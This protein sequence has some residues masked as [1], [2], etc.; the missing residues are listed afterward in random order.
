LL[1]LKKDTSVVP[2]LQNMLN[3]HPQPL[4]RIHALW[5]LEGLG[6]LTPA[7]ARTA[8][9]DQDPV[10][11]VQAIR[12][13]ESLLKAGDTSFV[14]DIKSTLADPH[15]QVKLQSVLTAKLHKF[16]DWKEIATQHLIT[17]GTPGLKDI[18]AALLT[19]GPTVSQSFSPA[20]R[21]QLERGL[22]IY[23]EVCFA[24]H[25][26]DGK[27]T[28]IPGSNGQTLAPPL[29]GSKTVRQGDALLR[30]LLNGLEG[31]I[32]GKT[33]ESQMIPQNTNSDEW[34]AD[35]SSYIRNAFGNSAPLVDSKQVKALRKEIGTRTTPWTIEEL[36]A[37]SPQPLPN[38]KSWKLGS[39]HNAEKLH[40]ALDGNSATRWD[41]K[42]EQAPDMWIEIGLPA[43]TKVNGMELH[44]AASPNDGPQKYELQGSSDGKSWSTLAKGSAAGGSTVISFPATTTTHLRILQQ[45]RKPG[46][47]W[48]IHELEILAS[49]R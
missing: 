33:Y 43:P 17:T 25:G 28:P 46:K 30:V 45:G 14:T 39:S 38:R 29:A 32:E 15:P 4:A 6:A 37:L 40:L 48:S 8:Y 36:R 44:Y 42:I 24:C 21:K 23:Q 20:D 11:R 41:S 47:Y 16:P 27:G 22:K 1:I 7:M 49:P 2:E 3:D 12:A 26:P 10:V 34:L 13:S 19:T 18:G 35:I 31:P 5:T 9:K